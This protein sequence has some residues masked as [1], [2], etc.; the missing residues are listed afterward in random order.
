MSFYS[1]SANSPRVNTPVHL[2]DEAFDKVDVSTKQNPHASDSSTKRCIQQGSISSE[3]EN[4]ASS[5]VSLDRFAVRAPIRSANSLSRER[6]NSTQAR[7]Q[8]ILNHE[9]W[10]TI[11]EQLSS[12]GLISAKQIQTAA[13]AVSIKVCAASASLIA[14]QLNQTR[15]DVSD[16]LFL[17]DNRDWIELHIRNEN[18]VTFDCLMGC[19]RDEG[20]TVSERN[21]MKYLNDIN[22]H[23][24]TAQEYRI[25]LSK[26]RN[27]NR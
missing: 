27:R 5:T 7:A 26:P 25:M 19:F 24:P 14:R 8:R 20:A 15:T 3:I 23:L 17:N 6:A 1:S 10:P 2:H 22:L 13:S 21:V 16:L 4:A 9:K 12:D 18:I 11:L